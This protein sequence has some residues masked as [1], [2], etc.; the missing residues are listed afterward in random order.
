MDEFPEL[1]YAKKFGDEDYVFCL[2]YEPQVRTL[3]NQTWSGR[4]FGA[5]QA[6]GPNGTVR[7]SFPYL[8]FVLRFKGREYDRAAVAVNNE[9]LKSINDHVYRLPLSNIYKDPINMG[10]CMYPD[11]CEAVTMVDRMKEIVTSFW[12]TSFTGSTP[13]TGHP[14]PPRVKTV[15]LW[16]AETKNDPSF[17]TDISW[18]RPVPKGLKLGTLAKLVAGTPRH[19]PGSMLGLGL[20]SGSHSIIVR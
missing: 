19:A 9:P 16:E 15:H 5:G 8:I 14:V 18:Q 1:K 11:K 3:I 10:L 12:S 4:G 20:G 13:H 2:Q 17:V 6:I 7:I